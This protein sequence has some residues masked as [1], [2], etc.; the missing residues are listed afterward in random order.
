LLLINASPR[1]GPVKTNDSAYE[2]KERYWACQDQ[3]CTLEAIQLATYLRVDCL[4]T[5]SITAEEINTLFINAVS[6]NDSAIDMDWKANIRAAN[7]HR[8]DINSPPHRIVTF[9]AFV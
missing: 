6:C 8:E 5:V 2:I 3:G 7:V 4:A 1:F 9:A